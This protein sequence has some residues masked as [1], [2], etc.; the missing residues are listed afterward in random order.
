MHTSF[1]RHARDDPDS[2]ALDFLNHDGSRTKWTFREMNAIS[3]G[4][5]LVLTQQYKVQVEQAIPICTP[6]SPA[7]YACVLAVLKCGA[8]FTPFTGSPDD[9]KKF[10]LEE[11]KARVVLTMDDEDM[12]WC[13]TAEVFNVSSLL[14]AEHKDELDQPFTSPSSLKSS[15]LAYQMY[16]SGEYRRTTE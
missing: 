14:A 9:R 12:S 16:T 3:D 11:L 5:A 4:I 7:F 15:N 1:E 10:M 8:V 6:K 13:D 2:L